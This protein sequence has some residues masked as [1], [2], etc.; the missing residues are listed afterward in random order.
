MDRSEGVTD[1]KRLA[2]ATAFALVV[3]C[4][5]ASG[6]GWNAWVWL[7][8]PQDAVTHVS[9]DLELTTNNGSHAVAIGEW[10]QQSTWNSWTSVAARLMSS[11]PEASTKILGY[12]WKNGYR[13]N[14]NGGDFPD[15]LWWEYDVAN[16][17]VAANN[18]Y[19][20]WMATTTSFN[21]D[22]GHEKCKAKPDVLWE[23][24]PGSEGIFNKQ[25]HGCNDT[26]FTG[27]CFGDV[28]PK[29]LGDFGDT[30]LNCHSLD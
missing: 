21:Q 19:K 17:C 26:M 12:E 29:M 15:E 1:M 18:N 10:Q 3:L 6:L 20:L 4:M 7:T 14:L 28:S 30:I 8:W 5:P 9:N 16:G 22:Y 11:N 25:G 27:V 23:Q 24:S 13:V 2:V